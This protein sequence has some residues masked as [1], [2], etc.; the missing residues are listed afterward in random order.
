MMASMLFMLF[1]DPRLYAHE[2]PAFSVG[3]VVNALAFKKPH[4]PFRDSKL[5][6]FLGEQSSLCA[7]SY[8]CNKQQPFDCLIMWVKAQFRLFSSISV[9]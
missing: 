2:Y 6:T 5:T 4:V 7:R 1:A 3:N 9:V 8:L